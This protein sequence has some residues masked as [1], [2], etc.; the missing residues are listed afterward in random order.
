MRT[1]P[2]DTAPFDPGGAGQK[3]IEGEPM[4]PATKTF[5]GRSY[6]VRGVSHCCRRASFNTA[7]R[8]PSVIASAWSC[9]TYTVVTPSSAWRAAMSVR[10]CTRSFAS[11]FESGSSMR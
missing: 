9:V 10:I 3:F 2:R 11:R 4:N 5:A 8:C 6:R 1:P 7:T